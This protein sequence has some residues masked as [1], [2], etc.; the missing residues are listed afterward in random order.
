MIGHTIMDIGL[1]AFWWTQIAG[2]FSARPISETGVDPPFLIACA[3][4][5]AGLAITLASVWR[6]R[7]QAS[8]PAAA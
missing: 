5:T 1:F 2:V 3:A 4:L 6:L 8:A 7:A